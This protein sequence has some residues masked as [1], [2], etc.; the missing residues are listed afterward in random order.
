MTSKELLYIKTIVEEGSISIAAKKLYMSQPSLSQSLKRIELNLSCDLFIRSTNGLKLTLAGEKY[1]Q[2]AT[3]IL[4]IYDDMQSQISDINNL[5]MGKI[6]LGITNHLGRLI[7]PNVIYNF[8]KEY[9]NIEINIIEDTSLQLENYLIKGEIDFAL[10]H[11]FPEIDCSHLKCEGLSNENFVILSSYNQALDNKAR[12]ID[13]YKYPV[14]DLKDIQYMDFISLTKEQS[15]RQMQDLI[16]KKA[17]INSVHNSLI[18]KSYMTALEF[19][20]KGIGIMIFPEEY[21]NYYK[22]K[23]EFSKKAETLYIYSIPKQYKPH[24]QLTIAYPRDAFL[25]RADEILLEIIRKRSLN[26]K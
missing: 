15:I 6:N 23:G 8:K 4:R 19:A 16:L 13:K 25:S 7:L 10:I 24:W 21:I 2:A 11:I 20:A 12:I 17:G 26:D 9:P 1:Y 5:K 14:L 22:S 18:V 3:K